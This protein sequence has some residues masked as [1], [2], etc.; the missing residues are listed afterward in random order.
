M[1]YC[2]NP[3]CSSPQNVRQAKVCQHCGTP[4]LLKDRY[5]GLNLMGQGNFGRTLLAVDD[6]STLQSRCVVKQFLPRYQGM[7][8]R[9]KAATL[10]RQEAARLAQLGSHPQIPTLLAY[11]EQD[12]YQYVIQD[13][14][15]GGNLA[16]ELAA[17]GPFSERRLRKLLQELLP[18]LDFMHGHHVIHRD[19][20]PENI[21]A[22]PSG[23]C[24]LVDFGAA[25][26]MT[27]TAL[28][29][30]GTLIGSASYAAP[31][32]AIGKAIFASDLYSLGV[33]CLHLLT[34]IPPFDLFDLSEGAWAWKDY[35]TQPISREL[36]QLLDRMVEPALKRRYGSAAEILADLKMPS[37]SSLPRSPHPESIQHDPAQPV[38]PSTTVHP[39]RS[40]PR[41]RPPM[42]GATP[43]PKVAAK[44]GCWRSLEG[45][46]KAVH[47]VAWSPNRQ[48]VA[49]ASEDGTLKLWDP[50]M[51]TLLRTL[52]DGSLGSYDAVAFSHD[53]EMVAGAGYDGQ[54]RLWRTHTGM[55]SSPL[56][57]HSRYV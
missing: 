40:T 55:P 44:W 43:S 53:G 31:E 38:S 15:E 23:S 16:Q 42:Q 49:S 54:I 45:H 46:S 56:K 41:D 33:T 18:V 25:K 48:Q 26:V 51:G 6:P 21:I 29:Q 57:G 17:L 24:V 20:K 32:Q 9:E 7:G 13:Y 50:V 34:Q 52:G 10:F 27:G 3:S 12:P 1:S 28:S 22:R 14:I 39:P 4:L 36:A 35:V 47:A 8:N 37:T 11:I 2:F 19:I 30:T 5:R